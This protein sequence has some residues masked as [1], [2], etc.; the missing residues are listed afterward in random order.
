[1]SRV[2]KFRVRE[3]WVGSPRWTSLGPA[4][5]LARLLEDVAGEGGHHLPGRPEPAPASS[6]EPEVELGPDYL[7]HLWQAD[8]LTEAP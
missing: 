4:R 5:A 8:G 3:D 2:W 1:M 6:L 7:E